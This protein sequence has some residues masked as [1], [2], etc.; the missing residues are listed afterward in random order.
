MTHKPQE[1]GGLSRRHAL[2]A[3][4]AAL[5]GAMLTPFMAMPTVRRDIWLLRLG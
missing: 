2:L 4:S 5:G 1:T 3:G